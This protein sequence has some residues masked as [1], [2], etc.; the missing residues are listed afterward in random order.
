M[1][2]AVQIGI[3]CGV[4]S[5]TFPGAAATARSELPAVTV[6][7]PKR[8]DLSYA[9]PDTWLAPPAD[10]AFLYERSPL[11]VLEPGDIEVRQWP[12]MLAADEDN[13]GRPRAYRSG[14]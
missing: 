6:D 9:S 8:I 4:L 3:L 10:P 14:D 2:Y 5:Q 12:I 1:R 7:A 11:P 13:R